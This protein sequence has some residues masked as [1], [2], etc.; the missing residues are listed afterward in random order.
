MAHEYIEYEPRGGR[1]ELYKGQPRIL[2]QLTQVRLARPRI[3]RN[4]VVLNAE[5]H[6]VGCPLLTTGIHHTFTLQL[7]A[8][9]C[10]FLFRHSGEGSLAV[11]IALTSRNVRGARCNVWILFFRSRRALSVHLQD[12]A[13]RF[14]LP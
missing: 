6:V 14:L 7:L 8:P 4:G 5:L 3:L 9:H 12:N 2:V 10:H 13:F 1:P 11:R